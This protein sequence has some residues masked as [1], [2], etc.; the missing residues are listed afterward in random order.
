VAYFVATRFV[1]PLTVE[2]EA[3]V[4]AAL[5]S[6]FASHV[7]GYRF[8]GIAHFDQWVAGGMGAV[9]PWKEPT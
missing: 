5:G 4:R 9:E 8:H 7:G 3:H 6:D 2:E 1:R